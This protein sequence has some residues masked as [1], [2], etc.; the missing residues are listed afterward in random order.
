VEES[1]GTVA[2]GRHHT[3]WISALASSLSPN[4]NK[5]R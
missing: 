4:S 2:G 5:W 1:T 3:G